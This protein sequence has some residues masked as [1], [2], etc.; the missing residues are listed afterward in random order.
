VGQT[1]WILNE[2]RARKVALSDLDIAA[3]KS[4]NAARGVEFDLPR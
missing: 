2:Q 1:L 3:T 4:A